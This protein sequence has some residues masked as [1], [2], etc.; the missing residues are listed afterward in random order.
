MSPS[1]HAAALF[2]DTMLQRYQS[3]HRFR[4]RLIDQ[5]FVRSKDQARLARYE[6]E[7]ERLRARIAFERKRFLSEQGAKV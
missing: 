3:D 7:T 6:A 5:R 1:E 4:K 2:F